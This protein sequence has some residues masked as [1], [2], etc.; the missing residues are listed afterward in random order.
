M[1]QPFIGQVIRFA[2]N[3]APRGWALCEG[4]LLPITSNTALFSLLG[5]IYGGDGRSTFGLP[6]LRGRVPVHPGRGPGLLSYTLGAKGGVETVTLAT[7]QIPSHNHL[8]ESVS[9]DGNQPKPGGHLPASESGTVSDLYSNADADG[10]MKASMIT[11]TGG[12]KNHENRQP[13]LTVNYII[14]LVGLYPSRS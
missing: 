11:H 12:G 13:Y 1:S 5:T 14:A 7:S 6:D 3:F 9:A 8:V 10:T 2:G 4:Q